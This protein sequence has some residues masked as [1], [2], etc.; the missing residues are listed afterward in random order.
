[1]ELFLI[2]TKGKAL[3]LGLRG[4]LPI[5]QE[6]DENTKEFGENIEIEYKKR[7]LKLTQM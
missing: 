1:M 3:D 4:V 6:V 2:R 7:K 5:K